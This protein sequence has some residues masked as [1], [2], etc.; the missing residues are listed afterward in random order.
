[1]A[2]CGSGRDRTSAQTRRAGRNIAD[3]VK[4][5]LVALRDRLAD[6]AWDKAAIQQAIKDTIGEHKL[7]MPQLAI[8]L[9]VLVC[10]TAQTPS[11]DAVLSLFNR[12]DVVERLRTV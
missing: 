3:A 9:R 2:S 10:G 5:A 4:P 6:V 8:P 7:K 11:I 1:M 12:N